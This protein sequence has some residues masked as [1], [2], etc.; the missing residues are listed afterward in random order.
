MLRSRWYVVLFAV[1]LAVA[2]TTMPAAARTS[3][4]GEGK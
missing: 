4:D 1:V 2:A 3:A